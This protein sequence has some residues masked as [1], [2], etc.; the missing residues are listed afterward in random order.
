MILHNL[1][2]N[3]QINT[4]TI[5]SM[6][7]LKNNQ[8]LSIIVKSLWNRIID[9]T[10][11]WIIKQQHIFLSFKLIIHFFQ[12]NSI[13]NL[14]QVDMNYQN[15]IESIFMKISEIKDVKNFS[16]YHKITNA[17]DKI[18]INFVILQFHFVLFCLKNYQ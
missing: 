9:E 13:Y 3:L 2:Q 18:S 15:F 7:K 17:E 10:T 4:I 5:S 1:N 12:I 14:I 11:N 6:I 8:I 16:F